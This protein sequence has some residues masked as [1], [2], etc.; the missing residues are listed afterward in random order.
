MTDDYRFNAAAVMAERCKDMLRERVADGA[1]I[2]VDILI[3]DG[4]FRAKAYHTCWSE[5]QKDNFAR[6]V[7]EYQSRTDEFSHVVNHYYS[8]H[9]EEHI[10][11][12]LESPIA[13]TLG[14]GGVES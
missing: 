14:L 7:V 4:S 10:E 8:G 6:E 13:N 2:T 9:H 12:A 1:P 5:H 11:Y 3:H